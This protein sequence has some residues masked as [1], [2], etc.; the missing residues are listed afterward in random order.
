MCEWWLSSLRS[1]AEQHANASHSFSDEPLAL[2]TPPSDV[3]LPDVALPDVG[4][5]SLHE[6]TT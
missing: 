3:T 5:L 6:L 4:S 2:H 1:T